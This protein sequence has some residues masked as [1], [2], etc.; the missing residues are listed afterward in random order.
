MMCDAPAEKPAAHIAPMPVIIYSNSSAFGAMDHRTPVQ[1]GCLQRDVR[2][3]AVNYCRAFCT[4]C[5][6]IHRA[7]RR[8]RD[9]EYAVNGS[10]AKESARQPD[11]CLGRL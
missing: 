4:P 6:Q 8:G 5:R 3:A 7:R 1:A 11:Q 9:P 10:T 2:V